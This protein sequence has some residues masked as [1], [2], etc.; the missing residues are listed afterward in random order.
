MQQGVVLGIRIVKRIVLSFSVVV[1]NTISRWANA[2][3]S[4]VQCMCLIALIFIT[5][6]Q[7]NK[8]AV[9]PKLLRLVCLLYC[10]QQIRRL[11][12]SGSDTAI[13]FIPNVLLAT[14]LAVFLTV[15]AQKENKES[16]D[17]LRTML[18]A[19][20]YMYGDMLDFLFKYGVLSLTL[21]AF[22]LGLFIQTMPPPVDPMRSFFTRMA[23]IVSTN[24]LYQGVTSLINSSKHMKLVESIAT[25][26]VLRLIILSM[27]SYLTYL[28]AAQLTL[29]T[30]AIAPVMLCIII[31]IE[32]L[33]PLSRGWISELCATYVILSVMNYLSNVL[34]WGATVILIMAHYVDYIIVHLD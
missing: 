26:S 23:G 7:L 25:A 32:V 3:M 1:V 9:Q 19:L 28:T 13:D 33:P 27:E 17:D 20:L 4:M 15:L 11:F 12:T 31:W 21:M 30:P 2:N 16:V 8:T 6:T 10:N 18:E 5:A 22:A 34:T 14:T 24:I 29:I